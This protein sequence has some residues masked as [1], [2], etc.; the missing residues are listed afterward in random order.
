M[1]RKKGDGDVVARPK[2]KQPVRL[3]DIRQTISDV[4]SSLAVLSAAADELDRK[5][6]VSLDLDGAGLAARGLQALASYAANVTGAVT[7]P[8]SCK[9]Y[10]PPDVVTP[11][12]KPARKK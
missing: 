6:V 12:P 3:A 2:R 7:S 10:A 1:G 11:A 8:H 9:T 5:G 4:E